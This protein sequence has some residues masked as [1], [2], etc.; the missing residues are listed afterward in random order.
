[1]NGAFKKTNTSQENRHQM[2]EITF[3]VKREYRFLYYFQLPLLI[4][5]VL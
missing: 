5:M 2:R 4:A 1:M 3:R